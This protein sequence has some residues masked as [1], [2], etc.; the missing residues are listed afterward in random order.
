MAGRPTKCAPETVAKVCEALRLGVSWANA[1]AHAGVSEDCLSDWRKRGETG[2]E[3]F[4]GFLWDATRA[5]DS[6]AVSMAALVVKAARS[7]NVGAAMWW[8]ERRAGWTRPPETQVAVNV[9]TDGGGQIE[10]LLKR[11]APPEE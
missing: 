3:P 2:E 7:G 6:A 1:A 8:L 5:R 11:L 9:S 10:A 4:A